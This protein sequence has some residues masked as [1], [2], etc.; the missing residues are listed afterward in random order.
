MH[1]DTYIHT[2]TWGLGV[3]EMMRKQNA[4]TIRSEQK[5]TVPV[6]K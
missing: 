3:I 2:S 6:G 5:G 4:E 1:S